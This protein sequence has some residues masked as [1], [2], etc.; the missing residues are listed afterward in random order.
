M[1]ILRAV[2]VAGVIGAFSNIAAHAA[3]TF[4]QYS[5]AAN[6]DKPAPVNLQ[7]HP[8]ARTF[9]TNLRE[10]ARKGPNFAGHFTIV[11]WG[12]GTNCIEG[13]VVD[14]RNGAV[15][16]PPQLAVIDYW[17]GPETPNLPA[18]Q[19]RASSELLVIAGRTS[20]HERLGVLYLRWSETHF[21]EVQFVSKDE[22]QEL[23]SPR[24]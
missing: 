4:E 1:T 14:A 12:C 8:K 17:G 20:V 18:L 6:R 15:Y 7:S 3:P 5:V 19:F 9:R 10:G 23:E 16:F 11:Q 13:A 24:S 2:V 21:D 22:W